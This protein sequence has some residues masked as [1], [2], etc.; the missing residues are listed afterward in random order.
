MRNSPFRNSNVGYGEDNRRT[1]GD[2]G[3][4]SS[5]DVG[6]SYEELLGRLV[7]AETAA[8]DVYKLVQTGLDAVPRG[9]R[10]STAAR[11]Q[12]DE[13]Q[14]KR[15]LFVIAG[16]SLSFHHLGRFRCARPL[17]S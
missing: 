15:M 16:Q 11:Q 7:A 14:S 1:L 17:H 5:E 9:I 6:D 2:D 4:E 3:S 13:K 8:D 12:N 10:R